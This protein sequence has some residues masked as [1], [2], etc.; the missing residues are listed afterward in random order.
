MEGN[1]RFT[2]RLCVAITC[3]R[4]I[5]TSE[6]FFFFFDGNYV[7]KLRQ[8]WHY[9]TA[10]NVYLQPVDGLDSCYQAVNVGR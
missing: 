6:V 8:A 9:C 4:G 1:R 3:R 10:L 2:L 7:S 5:K